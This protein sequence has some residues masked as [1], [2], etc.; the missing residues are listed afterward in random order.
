MEGVEGIVESQVLDILGNIEVIM[1]SR[2]MQECRFC[3]VHDCT[4]VLTLPELKNCVVPYRCDV[5][6]RQRPCFPRIKK[7][8]TCFPILYILRL[9][10]SNVTN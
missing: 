4:F 1:D 5:F 10:I 7:N 9:D 3:V 6:T 2:G 8:R